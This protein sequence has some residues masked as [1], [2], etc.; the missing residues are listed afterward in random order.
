M[1]ALTMRLQQGLR[2]LS[3]GRH[4]LPAEYDFGVLTPLQ[5]QAFNN[6]SSFDREHLS[7]V[8]D[9]VR[10]MGPLSPD[11]AAATLMH[12]IA[13][14]GTAAQP[15][16]VR[17]VH[18]VA[19]VCLESMPQALSTVVG[20]LPAP[21]WRAGFALARHHAELGAIEAARLGCSTRT[22][23]LIRHHHDPP[24]IEDTELLRLLAADDAAAASRQHT[25]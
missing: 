20:R 25:R 17:L 7:D 3:S 10:R 13:K 5:R 21:R 24:P 16:R 11:L 15:G 18:R 9:R 4:N 6:L 14:G 12:D 8:Y 22:C 2:A 19:A 23:W 1:P